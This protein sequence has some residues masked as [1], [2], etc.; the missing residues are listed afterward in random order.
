MS[1]VTLLKVSTEKH[2]GLKRMRLELVLTEDEYVDT[3]KLFNAIL[4]QVKSD[5]KRIA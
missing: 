2:T 3:A 5:K 1:A 4:K